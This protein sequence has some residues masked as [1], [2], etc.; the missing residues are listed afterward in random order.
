[1]QYNF[2]NIFL[3][4]KEL[5]A[6]SKFPIDPFLLENN[7]AQI[8]KIY[9]FYKG[10]VNLLYVNGFMGT[11]KARIVDYT[12]AFLSQE[13]IVL[14]YNC[15]NSTILDDM[16]L[17][18]FAEFKKLSAQNIISPPKVKTENFTQK[19]NA[20]FSQIEKPFVLI[21]NSF[22]EILDENRQEI[23]DFIL[24]LN[25]M[26]KV[27]IIIIGKTFESKYFKD[28]ELERITTLAL[29]RQ[30]VEKCFKSEKIKYTSGLLDEYYKHARGYYFFTILSIK[31]MKNETSVL[32]DFLTKL[33]NSYLPLFNFLEKQSI[34]LVPASE[35]NLFWF[36][37]L[38][39]HP[40]S[41]ELLKKLNFYKEEKF[42]FLVDNLII[43]KE[44]SEVFIR[45]FI[46]EQAEES[47][48][49]HIAQKIRQYI[50]DLYQTQLPL[51]PF[52][53]DICISRQ[54]MRKEMEYQKFFLPKKPQ[55]M[56]NV[57][58][59]INFLSYAQAN[60][61]SGKDIAKAS[62]TSEKVQYKTTT[63]PD[64]I[65]YKKNAKLNL[66]NIQAPD[67]NQFAKNN[68]QTE[69]PYTN[70]DSDVNAAEIIS[71]YE[72]LNLFELLG[73][74]SQ[75]EAN[76][77]YQDVIE[78]CKRALLKKDDANYQ[79]NLP[80]I[81]T[82]LAN[83]YE[84]I[85][86]HENAIQ[87]YDLALNIYEEKNDYCQTN[88]MKFNKANAFYESYKIE[89]AK[90]LFT[91]ITKTKQ[92][93]QELMVKSLIRLADIEEGQSKTYTAFEHYK[94][95]VE[96]SKPDM[97]VKLLSE[98]Y[99]KYA[100]AL[101]DKNDI[102]TAIEYYENCITLSNDSKVNKF[103]SSTY[104]NIATLY[105]EKRDTQ[106]ALKNYKKAYEIDKESHNVEGMYYSSSKL[107]SILQRKNPD[108][109]LNYFEKALDYAKLIKDV[110][111]IVSASLALG[112]FY[113]DRKQN[114][115]ALKYY[116]YSINLARN[117]FSQDNINKI[118]VRLN[119]IRFKLGTEKFEELIEIL[120][121]QNNE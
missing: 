94:K 3:N 84:K 1:M 57:P 36:L 51:K 79:N 99:F 114:E 104:S 90:N 30:L 22:E 34:G 54:T 67:E 65:V 95:A 81:Y 100:L 68:K 24:H 8:E 88:L 38:I 18:Y 102:K 13:A 43:V 93:D 16:L 89:N 47:I 92:C 116:F 101:D 112:D 12:T 75:A 52:E 11:G 110:F 28:I 20:Y 76:Y 46:R 26:P 82:K 53:R 105:L 25:S 45:E 39:R 59:D 78:L 115:I 64:D 80:L 37:A 72:N 31:M 71:E 107:A 33:K 9:N 85:A 108:E 62:Q 7:S 66:E 4:S 61:F 19:I 121:A 91:E 41:I 98:L 55:A 21:I 14:K 32:F 35:R 27:K 113:Y 119:D 48:A 109:A 106:N 56:E 60:D 50:I 97:D 96:L 10:S 120:K 23:I 83:A 40:V 49:P 117:N 29:S 58:V 118:K 74:A 111:Y 17:S 6:Q 103:L 69:Q 87:F 73:K 42:N 44:N 77:K 70:A 5:L 15:F 86:N 63:R 2:L